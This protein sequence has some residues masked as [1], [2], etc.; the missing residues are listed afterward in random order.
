MV[1]MVRAPFNGPNGKEFKELLKFPEGY[2]FGIIIAAGVVKSSKKPHDLDYGK[3][4][5]V[6]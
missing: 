2:N 5:Y 4:A 3:V 1:G 6:E